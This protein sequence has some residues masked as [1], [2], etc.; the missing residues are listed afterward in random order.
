MAQTTMRA[1]G[2]DRTVIERKAVRDGFAER[3][4]GGYGR[5]GGVS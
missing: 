5:D 1:I 3:V 4:D 2:E